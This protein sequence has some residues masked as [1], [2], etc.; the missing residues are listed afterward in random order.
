M[1]SMRK[2]FPKSRIAGRTLQKKSRLNSI[3]GIHIEV[4][5]WA[6]TKSPYIVILSIFLSDAYTY[7]LY[8]SVLHSIWNTSTVDNITIL[9]WYLICFWYRHEGM[10]D[11]GNADLHKMKS[12]INKHC[13][14]IGIKSIIRGSSLSVIGWI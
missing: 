8:K 1:H 2:A 5:L 9:L 4:V 12:R 13:H 7:L 3:D 10:L 11:V 14:G 6:R